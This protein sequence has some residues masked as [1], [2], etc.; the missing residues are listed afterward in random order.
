MLLCQFR[1]LLLHKHYTV[2]GNVLRNRRM[3]NERERE[4]SLSSQASTKKERCIRKQRKEHTRRP[5]RDKQE[6]RFGQHKGKAQRRRFSW[7]TGVNERDFDFGTNTTKAAR[8]QETKRG[9]NSRVHCARRGEVNEKGDTHI[10][11]LCGEKAFLVKEQ[12]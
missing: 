9:G 11:G 1:I 8:K 4:I 7:L 6:S 12:D 3:A 5:R 2:S 10:F